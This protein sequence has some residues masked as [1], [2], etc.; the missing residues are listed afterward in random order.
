MKIEFVAQSGPAE[1][2]A[3]LVHEDR[4]LAGVGSDHDAATSGALTRAMGKSRFKGAAMSSHLVAAPFGLQADSVLLVGAGDAPD[5]F[6]AAAS[7]F[8]PT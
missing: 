6:T 5:R 2:L 7:S 3:V 8:P 4:V 1:I